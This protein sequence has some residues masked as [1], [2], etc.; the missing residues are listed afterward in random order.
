MLFIFL[1][2][3]FVLF[4]LTNLQLPQFKLMR[5][6]YRQSEKKTEGGSKELKECCVHVATRV[7]AG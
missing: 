7:Y 5:E 3:D 6:K 1:Q 2:C 4:P